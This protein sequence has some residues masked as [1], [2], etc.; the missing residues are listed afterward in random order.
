MDD[1]YDDVHE[2]MNERP[3]IYRFII[4]EDPA[5]VDS[6]DPLAYAEYL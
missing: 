6:T 1:M 5:N 2:F 4:T 3:L